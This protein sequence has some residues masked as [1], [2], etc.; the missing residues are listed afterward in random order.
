M[1]LV[2]GPPLFPSVEYQEAEIKDPSAKKPELSKV[3]SF[4]HVIDQN[5]VLHASNAATYSALK[6]S[7]IQVHFTVFYPQYSSNIK[8]CRVT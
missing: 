2:V 4:T 7:A 5:K 1:V 3:Q 6:K 8:K